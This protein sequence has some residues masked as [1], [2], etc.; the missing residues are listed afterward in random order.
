MAPLAII[1]FLVGLFFASRWLWQRYQDYLANQPPAYS[2]LKD[3][4]SQTRTRVIRHYQNQ[5]RKHK[6]PRNSEQTTQEHATVYS[7]FDELS[8]LVDIAAYRP[9]PPTAQELDSLE[10]KRLP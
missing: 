1:A 6:A 8:K 9:E 3:A 10:S 2:I 7:E 4:D 5:Q